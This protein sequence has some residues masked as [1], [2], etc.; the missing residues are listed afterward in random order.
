MIL[1]SATD[2]RA[3]KTEEINADFVVVGGGLAGTCAAIAAAR[4][5]LKTILVQDRPVLGGNASSEVRLWVLGATSHMG[6]N[7]RW[8]REG[9]IM[10][11]I[12]EDNLHRNRHGNAIIFDT[13]LLEKCHLED[14]LTLLLNTAVFDLK[15]SDPDT[16]SEVH[17][18]CSQNS[19]RYHLH[20]PTF[21]DASGDGIVGFM[22]GAAF[23][24]GAESK[25]EFDEGFAPDQS[26]GE[27]LGHSLYFYT[28][29]V[30]TPISYTAPEWALKDITKIPRYRQFNTN[31]QGCNFWWLEYGGRLDT[32]HETENIKW[33][34]WKVVY[35]VWDHI[36]NSGKFPEA[37]TMTLEWVGHI[38]GKRESRRFE[39]DYM[40]RQQDVIDQ[41]LFED[42]I[43]H[44]GWAIDLHPADGVY[45]DKPSCTQWHSKGVYGLPYRSHYSKNINNLFLAGRIISATHVAFG[46]T[47]VMATCAAGGQAVG[48]AAALC[49]KHQCSPRDISSGEKLTELQT[50][51]QRQG[52]FI[53]G[54][55]N[56]DPDDLAQ[57]AS[58]TTSST[59]E[60]SE[61]SP[62]EDWQSLDL[63]AAMLLP[64]AEASTPSFKLEVDSSEDTQLEVSLLLPHKIEGFTPGKN[65][66]TLTINI[67]AGQS[68]INLPFTQPTTQAGYHFLIFSENPIL[69]LRRSDQ[70][71]TGVLSLFASYNKAVATTNIQSP[72]EDIGV[73]S[74]E[75]W[76]PKRRPAGKNIALQVSPPLAAFGKE[77]LTSSLARPTQ[78]TNAWVADPTDE[79]PTVTLEWDEPVTI[80]ELVLD[81]DPDWDH[82]LESV[83]MTHPEEV[84]PFMVQ[85]FH[86]E[87][88]DGTVVYEKSNNHSAHHEIH[89]DT[90][91]TTRKLTLKLQQPDSTP[92]A[93]FRIQVY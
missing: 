16:I 8:A 82:P 43:S 12:M 39:G 29:D 79:N 41:T 44:G 18:F 21:C 30:G 50:S 55:T 28:K 75:F 52:Q 64:L 73:D 56:Q 11:E 81:F 4:Q 58:I 2:Q 5:G 67:P 37:E 7:N 61:L 88:E 15:K 48:T 9:G 80:S 24:M 63:A 51:L 65:L 62:A 10:N 86:I 35:G 49:K 87:N 27:L 57:S 1:E 36:K 6:N 42:S 46:S 22:A 40:I 92:A 84:S 32:V 19:I 20:A 66:E 26:Y 31:M 33:E 68:E 71:L 59:L 17:A 93:L 90:P 91:I 3:L 70:R 38:P 53:P 47:R 45:S 69:K 77:N 72:P 85:T 14:N 78:S 34:L 54:I 74:F 25:E 89:L 76:L 23:R 13:I 60:L 83:L